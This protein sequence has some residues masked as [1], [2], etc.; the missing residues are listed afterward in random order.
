MTTITTTKPATRPA[1]Y[2]KRDWDTKTIRAYNGMILLVKGELKKGRYA[3]M[4]MAYLNHPVVKELFTQCGIP[5]KEEYVLSLLFAM[6]RERR[7]ERHV[8]A[9]SALRKWF[10]GGWKT[11]K[12]VT[13]TQPKEPKA[14]AKSTKKSKKTAPKNV[15]EF[16]NALTDEQRKLIAEKIAKLQSVA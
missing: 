11:E 12:P 4:T 3:S 13:Y 7:E 15:D 2:T 8:V 10:N 14:P 5:Q 1:C 9:V 16:V 6:V